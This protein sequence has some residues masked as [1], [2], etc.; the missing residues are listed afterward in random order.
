MKPFIGEKYTFIERLSQIKVNNE[1]IQKE[2][3]INREDENI[4]ISY[5]PQRKGAIKKS[6]KNNSIT[7]NFL[8][9]F[10]P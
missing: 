3:N 10:K 7:S 2:L 9:I 5:I 4:S 1:E 8:G 6:V